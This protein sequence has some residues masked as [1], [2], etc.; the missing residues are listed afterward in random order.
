MTS[1]CTLK[2]KE[3]VDA[4]QKR[5]TIAHADFA[6]D[7]PDDEIPNLVE[8]LKEM[9]DTRTF[10]ENFE[11]DC[12]VVL[13]HIFKCKYKLELKAEISQK[14]SVRTF[15]TKLNQ[16]CIGGFNDPTKFKKFDRLCNDLNIELHDGSAA[17]SLGDQESILK[18]FFECL[19]SI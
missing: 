6:Q 5:S 19:T 1:A 9:L 7:F 12:R 15:T 3:T 13:E 17:P 8:R 11:A 16:D 2:I 4:E 14:K 18:D 10:A